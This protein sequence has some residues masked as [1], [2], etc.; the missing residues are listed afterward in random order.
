[1][2]RKQAG[3]ALSHRVQSIPTIRNSHFSLKSRWHVVCLPGHTL[4]F[5]GM[6]PEHPL[7]FWVLLQSSQEE[8]LPAAQ[9]QTPF[10]RWWLITGFVLQVLLF[11]AT[12]YNL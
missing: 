10:S 11:S 12:E 7:A 4:R 8:P 6:R 3:P 2:E 5:P 9:V 1:M